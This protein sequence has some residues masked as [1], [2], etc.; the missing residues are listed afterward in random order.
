MSK[1]PRQDKVKN[2]RLKNNLQ[3]TPVET[4]VEQKDADVAQI[5]YEDE[6]SEFLSEI[7]MKREQRKVKRDLKDE[8]ITL[9]L[10]YDQIGRIAVK[11]G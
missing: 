1:P 11:Y 7:N 6:E 8:V 5:Y 2:E 4:T 10:K 3:I 9:V